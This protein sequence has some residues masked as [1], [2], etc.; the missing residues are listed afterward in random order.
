[1]AISSLKHLL[2]HDDGS[3]TVFMHQPVLGWDDNGYFQDSIPSL[4][5]QP[6]DDLVGEVYGSDLNIGGSD[7]DFQ[8][9]HIQYDG[10][11][12]AQQQIELWAIGNSGAQ[13]TLLASPEEDGL[14][15]Y[16]TILRTAIKLCGD[17]AQ[18]DKNL[19]ASAPS[20]IQGHTL[21]NLTRPEDQ[22]MITFDDGQV[23]GE[24]NEPLEEA[25]SQ[26]AEHR[27]C[28][29]FE[30]FAPVRAIRETIT[31]ATKEKEAIVRV[32]IN[33][34]GPSG[35]GESVGR[36][37]SRQ[38]IYLQR[39]DYMRPGAEHDNPHVLKLDDRPSAV[40]EVSV[41]VEETAPEKGADDVLKDAIADVYSSLTRE[42]HL[43]GLE[44]D[45]RLRTTLLP[46]QKTALEFMIER[47]N[48]P[49]SE[50]YRLWEPTIVDGLSCNRHATTGLICRLEP[51]DETGG[52]ILADEMGM[53]KSLS[54][55]ALILR[56]L[57]LAQQWSVQ[58]G[59]NTCSSYQSRPRSRATLIVASSD[60]M[61]NEWFQEL[62]KHFDRQTL[63]A[64]R[65]IK[66]HGP[67]RDRS[68]A[69]LRDADIIITTYHALAAEL[70][71]STTLI[72]DID[73]YRLVLDEAHIIR[74][75]STGLNRA[76]SSIQAHSRWCLTGTPIQNRLEDIGSLLSFLRIEPFHALA[77][78]RKH[79][80]LPFDEG[81]KTR[82][83]AIERFTRLLDAV[84]LRRT[85]D[86]LHLPDLENI[87]RTVRLSPGERN[88][89]EQTHNTMWR[90][91]RHQ[92]GVLDSKSTLG[93]FQVQL[94]LR[95]ICNHGTWQ[96]LFSWNRRK[97]HLLDEREAIEVSLGRESERTCS[98]CHGS[99]PVFGTGTSFHQYEEC[100]HILCSECVDGSMSPG[101]DTRPS[102][103]PMCSALWCP[104]T[105]KHSQKYG[106]QEDLYFRPE[107]HSSKLD[108]LMNDV[109]YDVYST[110]S[111]IFT[112]WTRTLDLIQMYLRRSGL[113]SQQFQRIDGECPTT[114]RE[115]ILSDFANNPDLRVLIMTTGTGAVGLNL[116]TANRVF[117]VEPQWNPSVENQAI[118]RAL[119][120][121]QKQSVLVVRYVVD[122]T[123]ELDMRALQDKKLER[124]NL[125]ERN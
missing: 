116:A 110:K 34:Y 28:L 24:V 6:W 97:L 113:A 44:G 82:N 59:Q 114:K 4:P 69:T 30:V 104:S 111:I 20:P 50:A 13:S 25:L 60:L 102:R 93:M 29:D 87:I 122:Q 26:F 90:A 21:L 94:Q 47:E 124:A 49:I 40:P 79:I 72:S 70:A 58:F 43:R 98:A 35:M 106:S 57:V 107:G 33:V 75:Q 7:P 78:F 62:D 53:G 74:R 52:G 22:F 55:L 108:M 65:T 100:R 109:M 23:L 38:K 84:C 76:V 1:M 85:K 64:L 11:K 95:I 88:Q 51:P 68:V 96:Q 32:Q 63:Q 46:H 121:G 73:W 39:P 45:S 86:L 37:L 80:A 83:G 42:Q 31:R 103:C 12:D 18:L 2:N 48:G 119:R 61:I 77:T 14:I 67:N 89:Y 41:I 99:M 54:V 118:A 91:I 8:S 36:E 92:H 115:R 117:I 123:V 56:T 27:S 120:L 125:V 19:T 112:C 66:Y 71:S 16:G 17:M 10:L 101:Q 5:F 105:N 9:L 15:C 3:D 81:G